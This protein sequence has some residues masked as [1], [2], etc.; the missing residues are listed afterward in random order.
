MGSTELA[1]IFLKLS[2]SRQTDGEPEIIDT[3][4]L[5]GIYDIQAEHGRVTC[6]MPV[7]KRVQNR[8]G[9]LH[10]G[11]TATLVDVVGTAALLTMNPRA[12]VSISINTNYLDPMPGG[13]VV[14]IDA[15]V[16]K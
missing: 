10:G 4:A 3:T 7:T 5:S 12:G 9:H 6:K 2:V 13:K 14:L 11:C 8:N 16:R 15:K 1:C